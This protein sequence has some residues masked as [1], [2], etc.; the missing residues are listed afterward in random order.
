MS[1]KGRFRIPEIALGFLLGASFLSILAAAS[2]PQTPSTTTLNTNQ[3]CVS[4]LLGLC[5]VAPPNPPQQAVFG[6]AQFLTIFALLMAAYTLSD[7]RY[8]FRIAVTPIPPIKITFILTI[9]IGVAALITNVWFVQAWPV[10][11]FLASQAIIEGVLGACF[12]GLAILW[13]WTAFIRPPRFSVRNSR[14]FGQELYFRLLEG[15]DSELPTIASEI[16]RSAASIV[17][18]ASKAREANSKS[19]AS[20]AS[21]YAH[22]II[23]LIGMRKFCRHVAGSA[24]GTAIIFFTEISERRAYHL[25]IGQFATNVSTEAFLNKDSILYHEDEGYE[26]GYFGYL[27]PF[28]KAI[29]GDFHLLESLARSNSPLDINFDTRSKFDS[30]RLEAYSRALLITYEA[31]LD[32]KRF[33]GHSSVLSRAFGTLAGACGDLYELNEAAENSATGDIH[34]KL[35]A[36]VRFINRAIDLIEKGGVRPTKLR[37][38]DEA[39]KWRDDFYDEIA[40]LMFEVIKRAAQVTTTKFVSWEIQHNAVWTRFFSLHES[41]TRS[42]VLFKLRRLLYEEILS[43]ERLPHFA[44]APILGFCLNVMGLDV[45]KKHNH[46]RGE[47]QLRKVVVSWAKRNYLWM[48]EQSPK[49][50][51]AVLIGRLSFD[52]PNKR[53]VKTYNEG[54]RSS[55]PQDYLVLDL[56]T[57]PIVAKD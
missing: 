47:Y 19:T 49:A 48:N 8:R 26:S 22:D 16:G 7:V 46:T 44:N 37:R 31:A 17:Y 36:V 20:L 11:N 18:W 25:P 2:L 34:N 21:G 53:L 39:Y 24:P 14:K 4:R 42:I 5:L 15:V 38:K 1:A 29:Y 28:T 56:P 9:F 6:F 40:Y 23:L 55:P 50:A 30:D 45:G 33:Y 51:R 27:K 52:E 54:L 43:I 41:K 13:I 3:V 10:P 35:N 32:A 57:W 12:F